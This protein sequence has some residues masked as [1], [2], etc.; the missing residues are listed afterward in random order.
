LWTFKNY[1]VAAELDGNG[2]RCRSA[3]VTDSLAVGADGWD[4]HLFVLAAEAVDGLMLPENISF[5]ALSARYRR[6][7]ARLVDDGWVETWT[8]T[9]QGENMLG[10]THARAYMVT[11][12][13]PLSLSLWF[14]AG[15]RATNKVF[16]E[17][18]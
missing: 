8:Y 7:L 16:N 1:W 14:G 15:A 17:I 18:T 2:V 4:S 13:L 9:N 10:T 3:A 12:N 6:R 11:G 5:S